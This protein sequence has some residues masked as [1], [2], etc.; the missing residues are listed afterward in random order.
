MRVYA[1]TTCSAGRG[2]WPRAFVLHRRSGRRCAHCASKSA[3]SGVSGRRSVTGG[4]S[5]SSSTPLQEHGRFLE[6]E[7]G[8]EA[9]AER[10]RRRVR[11]G[12]RAAVRTSASAWQTSGLAMRHDAPSV[13]VRGS[14][15]GRRHADEM[16]GRDFITAAAGLA[17]HDVN[18]CGQ[19]PDRKSRRRRP[20]RNPADGRD[21]GWARRPAAPAV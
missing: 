5:P 8:S 9:L 1:L 6:L 7:A 11:R 20:G 19:S 3:M 2:P 16:A 15:G 4:S 13:S 17:G 21:R 10:G 12:W 18:G 14:H